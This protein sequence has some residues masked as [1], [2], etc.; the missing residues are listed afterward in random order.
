MNLKVINSNSAGN[1]YILEGKDTALLI[2]CGVN[3]ELIKKAIGFNLMKIAACAIT[4]EHKDHCKSVNAVAQNGIPIAASV[5]TFEAMGFDRSMQDH[6]L[7]HIS[8]AVVGG[9][10]IRSFNIDHDA[11]EPIGFIFQ[12]NDCG[13]VLFVT[14][15]YI[16]KYDFGIAFDHVIIEANY[17]EDLAEEWKRGKA[18]HFIERRRLTNHMSYQTAMLTLSRLDLSRCKNIVLIHLSDGLTDE[19]RFKE[20]TENRFGI[21]TTVAAPDQSINFSINSF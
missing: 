5:G 12:H 18:N 9:W 1:A 4:H 14:D 2:E 16:L 17:C 7:G 21:K 15:T 6:P 19:K 10:I 11:A 13:K 3:F 20:D 8:S